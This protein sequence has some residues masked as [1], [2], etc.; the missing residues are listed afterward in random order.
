MRGSDHSRAF[1][2]Y[3]SSEAGIIVGDMLSE[4][5]RVVTGMPKRSERPRP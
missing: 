4:Y 1:R 2:L 5:D 3:E